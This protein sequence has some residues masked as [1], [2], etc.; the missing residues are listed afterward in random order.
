MINPEDLNPLY[1]GDPNLV[2]HWPIEIYLRGSRI[3]T[4][5][6]L[7]IP[8]KWVELLRLYGVAD[9]NAWHIGSR[10]NHCYSKFTAIA[11][12]FVSEIAVTGT[13]V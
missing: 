7:G 13:A 1:N 12:C 9:R 8:S 2:S 3:V 5:S 4:H 6:L 10:V 11:M